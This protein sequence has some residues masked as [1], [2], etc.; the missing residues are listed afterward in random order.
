MKV[1]PPIVIASTI[2]ITN[3]D[4]VAILLLSN[5]ERYENLPS[6]ALEEQLARLLTEENNAL[7]Y[8]CINFEIDGLELVAREPLIL[9]D[10]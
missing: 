8:V 1:I 10:L 4:A 7:N 6:I 2:E 9:E 5:Q 3:D